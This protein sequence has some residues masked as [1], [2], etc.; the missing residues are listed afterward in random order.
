L[1]SSPR[2]EL[3]KRWEGIL[4][5]VFPSSKRSSTRTL[6]V[7]GKVVSHYLPV[8]NKRADLRAAVF[9]RHAGRAAST[10]P[11]GRFSA[12]GKTHDLTTVGL[13]DQGLHPNPATEIQLHAVAPRIS[14]ALACS[15]LIVFCFANDDWNRLFNGT[16]FSKNV[17]ATGTSH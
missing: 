14:F 2:R 16:L 7:F 15:S 1:R 8:V 10:D 17:S 5:W 4:E 11:I 3:W 12:L 9:P 13:L 6:G